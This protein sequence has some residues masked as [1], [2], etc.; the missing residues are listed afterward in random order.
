M[1]GEKVFDID[2]DNYRGQK[3]SAI[4]RFW[5]REDLQDAPKCHDLIKY[6]GRGTAEK[7][8]AFLDAEIGEV[9]ADPCNL[10]FHML[11]LFHFEIARRI[12]EDPRIPNWSTTK[13]AIDIS[14]DLDTHETYQELINMFSGSCDDRM[15]HDEQLERNVCLLKFW[16][17]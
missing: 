17:S 6:L 4:I 7:L 10:R 16:S 12:R 1:N 14:M 13:R 5:I 15:G 8:E 11:V 2:A 9:N 3:R